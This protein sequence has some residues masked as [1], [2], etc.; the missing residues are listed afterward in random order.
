MN[1]DLR[2]FV[3]ALIFFAA[4]IL[5]FIQGFRNLREKRLIENTP[6]S[7]IEGLAMGLVEVFGKAKPF[8]EKI[9]KSPFTNTDCVYYRYTIEEYRSSGKSGHYVTIDEQRTSD[10]F[11]VQ[12]ET[13]KVLVNP[14][15]AEIN[16]PDKTVFKTNSSG[17]PSELIQDFIKGR[18]ISYKGTFGFNKD[19]IFTEYL[20]EPEDSIFVMGTAGDN[21]FAPKDGIDHEDNILIQRGKYEKFFLISDSNEKAV[22]KQLGW[23]SSGFIIGGAALSLASLAGIL[24]Y[25]GAF[26]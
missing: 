15:G 22:L 4:G 24:L 3:Y 18:G 20:I 7:K 23:R 8:Q 9:H 11:F 14:E 10:P 12:D 6:T 17:E 19:M 1:V 25:L 26:G 13:G 5:L 2:V 21:P 16:K